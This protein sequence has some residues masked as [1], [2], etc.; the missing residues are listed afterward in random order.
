M[1]NSTV[2]SSP[3]SNPIS[4][5]TH[6]TDFF[7]TVYQV[8]TIGISSGGF[9]TSLILFFVLMIVLVELWKIRRKVKGK[10]YEISTIGKISVAMCL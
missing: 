7:P 4:S 6:A 3:T 1:A 5:S 8:V 2:T 10:S 9:L